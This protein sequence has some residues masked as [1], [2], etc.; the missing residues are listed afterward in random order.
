[1]SYSGRIVFESDIEGTGCTYPVEDV[2]E[3]EARLTQRLPDLSKDKEEFLS[4]MQDILK[5]ECHC[6]VQHGKGDL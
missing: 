1:M 4:F 5:S 6:S 3:F 2:I